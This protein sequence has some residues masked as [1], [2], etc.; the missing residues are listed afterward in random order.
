MTKTCRPGLLGMQAPVFTKL[1]RLP[2]PF[3]YRGTFN[4]KN[5]KR[6]DIDGQ[7]ELQ[8]DTGTDVA[9]VVAGV[10]SSDG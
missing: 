9:T 7:D 6:T 3:S 5:A 1:Q 2:F 4:K 10:T 8:A